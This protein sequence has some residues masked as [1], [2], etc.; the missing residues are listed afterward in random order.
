MRIYPTLLT[1]AFVLLSAHFLR[2]GEYGL[3]ACGLLLAG[4]AVGSRQAWVRPVLVAALGAG[5]LVWLDTAHSLLA[6]RLAAGLPW[7]RLVGIMGAVSGLTVLAAL[8]TAGRPGQRRFAESPSKALP[9]A[10]AVVLTTAAL[11]LLHVKLD[12]TLL[13]LERYA[14]GWG[15][16]EVLV[17]GLY[18]GWIAGMLLAP[19]KSHTLRP[20]IWR[21]FSAVFFGQLLLG[22]AGMSRMLMT[23]VLHLPVP[24]L[25]AAG[26]LYRGHGLFMLSLFLGTMALVGPAW[27]SHLCYI[28]AW[29]DTMSRLGPKRPRPR[30]AHTWAIRLGLAVAVLGAA[31]AMRLA[32]VDAALAVWAAAL[33]GL[34]GVAVMATVSR[35]KGYMVHCTAWC[36]MGIFANVLGKLS[37]WRLRMSPDCTGCGR[38]SRQCRYGALEQRH[39][40]RRS[41]G[42]TC[43]LC[44][45]CVHVCKHSA[46]ELTFPGMSPESARG[47]FVVLVAS[48][49][50]VFMGVARM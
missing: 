26:P 14:P 6:V 48:L 39:V 38:C 32:G 47:V 30:L 28:G 46:L 17:L 34:G 44:L 50:A 18:A 33:F 27:C 2:R 40:E 3:V 45:D 22:L 42:L 16:L 1:L 29:D 24:A 11:G 37:P 35:R 9:V 15:W 36:P 5:T 20:R 12:L 4:L 7:V 43:T 13:L 49:H 21:L 31:L 41:P 19:D 10:S 8:L 23:G 25:I